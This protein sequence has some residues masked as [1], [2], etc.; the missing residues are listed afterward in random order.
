L[1]RE[2]NTVFARITVTSEDTQ[3]KVLSFGYSDRVR[4]FLNG[5]LLYAGNN[6]FRTRDYRYLGT[7]GFFDSVVLPLTEGRNELWMA[8]SE[9]FGGWGLQ[10]AFEDPEGLT[11]VD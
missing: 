7:I 8:V 1:T 6:G 3:S 4:V 10:A 9:S 11:I 5:R 2:A